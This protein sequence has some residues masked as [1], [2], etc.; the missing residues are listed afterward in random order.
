MNILVVGRGGREHSMILKLAASEQVT[1]LYAAPGNAG[2][3][4]QATCV[5]IDEMDFD[6][7]IHFAKEN[8]IDL[9]VVGPEDPLNAG[10]ADQFRE[11]GLA[12]FAPNKAAAL[13][14]GSKDFAK[15]FMTKHDI[16]TADY[17]TFTDADQAKAYIEKKIGRASCRER[18]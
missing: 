14:E 11:E 3:A 8:A 16:P 18:G 12:I 7:L 5:A 9:T 13:L 17:A 10:I 6:G 1:K 15:Q 2:I 4:Q